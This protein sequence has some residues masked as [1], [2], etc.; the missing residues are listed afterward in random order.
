MSPARLPFRHLGKC[1]DLS[2]SAVNSVARASVRFVRD[3]DA[4]LV[5]PKD[6]DVS[7]VRRAIGFE[8]RRTVADYLRGTYLRSA[9]GPT[10]AP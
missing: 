10:S 1:C 5:L 3:Q 9:R 6:A 8:P 4:R 2:V 7:A